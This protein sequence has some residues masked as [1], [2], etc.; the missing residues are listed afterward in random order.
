VKAMDPRTW[1]WWIIQKHHCNWPEVVL[2][3][4]ILSCYLSFGEMRL[5]DIRNEL[6]ASRL[7]RLVVIVS[8]LHFVLPR[9]IEPPCCC[10]TSFLTSM[11]D[12]C[13]SLP[14]ILSRSQKQ[15][16]QTKAGDYGLPSD[17]QQEMFFLFVW[18]ESSFSF[19]SHSI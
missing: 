8:D 6:S 7:R 17:T 9:H 12:F 15:H 2:L 4:Q 18:R 16:K 3:L 13:G 19:C 5:F 1:E 10:F 11:Q 14:C